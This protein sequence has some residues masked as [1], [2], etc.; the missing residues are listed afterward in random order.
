ML[1]HLLLKS[2]C[3]AKLADLLDALGSIASILPDDVVLSM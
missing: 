2:S 1:S 3:V